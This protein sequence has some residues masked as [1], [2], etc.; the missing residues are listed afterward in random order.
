MV[1]F[2]GLNIK[3]ETLAGLTTVLAL[4][5][6]VIAFSVVAH[7]SPLIALYTTFIICLIT[8]LIGGRPGMI[9]GA[10]GSVAIVVT[11]LV[12][13]HGVEY[14][15]AAVVLMGIIQIV[16]GIFKLGKFIRLVPEAVIYGFLN[17][18][19][20]VI[21]ISQ[22]SQFYTSG[23]ELL[24]G[25][26]LLIMGSFVILAMVIIY[27]LPKITKAVPSSLVA[28]IVITFITIVFSVETKTVGDIA[29]IAGGLPQF[30][31]PMVPL[32]FETLKIIFPYS[33]IMA[34]VG[35]IESLLSLNVVDEMTNT[36]G[37]PNQETI[38]Q[39]IG[40]TICGL[41]GG[42]GGCAM[43][44]QSIVNINSGGRMKLSGIVA[45]VTL[46]LIILFGSSLVE[47]IPM[48]ALIGVMFM[49]AINTFEWASFRMLKRVLKVDFV[50]M[51]IVTLITVIFNN[52]AL[53]VIVGV[54]IS[55]IS[56]AWQTAKKIYSID[57]YDKKHDVKYYEI[58]GPL[59]FASVTGFKEL[60]DYNNDPNTVVIDFTNSKVLDHSAIKTLN[61][62]TAKYRNLNKKVLLSH[63]SP[64]C[65]YLLDNAAEIMEINYLEDPYYKVPS[66]V[67][68]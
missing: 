47:M 53:A 48:A 9:S 23:G 41:F 66:D 13:Q 33:L 42:M 8:A 27:F 46:L 7:V 50:V 56:F 28:I 14:L 39:G 29:S 15:F 43:I 58:Q 65:L 49:V 45:A 35:L 22:F 10:A 44:G 1:N 18:L 54:I 40:N 62:L 2:N 67:L 21:V 16:I 4:I 3:N 64:D 6:E 63:L 26:Q 55:A 20:I 17:G 11:A 51:L 60:F 34:L 30:H 32:N 5:P 31:I 38:A 52:L 25:F 57:S 68:D 12:V 19:A 37:K 36:R 59:F 24:Q 61:E